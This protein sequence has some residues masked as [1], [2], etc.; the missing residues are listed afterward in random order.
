MPWVMASM[1]SWCGMVCFSFCVFCV[2][3]VDHLVNGCGDFVYEV[4]V[5]VFEGGFC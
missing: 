3:L 5:V 4:G 1:V 2:P